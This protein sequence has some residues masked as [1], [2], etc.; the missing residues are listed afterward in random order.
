MPSSGGALQLA[1][2]AKPRPGTLVG[3]EPSGRG[4]PS[5]AALA[6]GA[7]VLPQG[8]L[9]LHLGLHPHLVQGEVRK[10]SG[11]PQVTLSLDPTAV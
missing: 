6:V 11:R 8:A 7:G 9:Q 5:R 10:A 2:T 3:E 1:I 4:M